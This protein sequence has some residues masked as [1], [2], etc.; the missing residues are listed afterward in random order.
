MYNHKCILY[1]VC[2]ICKTK[3]KIQN[4]EKENIFLEYY[5]FIKF[6]VNITFLFCI[7][8]L[9]KYIS[10]FSQEAKFLARILFN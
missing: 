5:I 1:F 2:T 4:F 7:I 9:I 6:N 3:M 10:L 8:L